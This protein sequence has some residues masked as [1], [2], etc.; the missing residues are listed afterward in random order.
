MKINPY[1]R[2]PKNFMGIPEVKFKK[3]DV[4]VLPIPYEVTV[5]GSAGTERG[6]DAI[7][8]QSNQVEL[9]YSETGIETYKKVKIYTDIGIEPIRSSVEAEVKRIEEVVG[10]ILN[11]DKKER[12][13]LSL[14]GEHTV[15]IGIL[16][17]FTKKYKNLTVL[18]IDAHPDLREEWDDSKY[19]HACAMRRAYDYGCK[20]V[21][22]G[23]REISEDDYLFMKNNKRIISFPSNFKEDQLEDIIEACTENV[24]LTLD[25]DG[26]DSSIMPATGTPS[27]NGLMYKQ[28]L[29][30]IEAVCRGKNL[31]GADIVELAPDGTQTGNSCAFT[32]AKIAYAIIGQKFR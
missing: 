19:S 24:Y 21:N 29:D 25:V 2:L 1:P 23:A 32:C 27:P 7:I 3:A 4:V 15:T 18:Q 6:P 10:N 30:V 9:F 20:I 11:Y 8:E 31:V 12:F 13:L 14:G 5:S 17:P 26:F 22:I 28:V 16:K